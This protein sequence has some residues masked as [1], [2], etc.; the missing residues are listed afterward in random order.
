MPDAREPSHALTVPEQD[1]AAPA[2][3]QLLAM[4]PE[5]YVAAA[6]GAL[7]TELENAIT[8]VGMVV[9]DVTTPE[10]MEAAKQARMVFRQLR[11]AVDRQHKDIKAPILNLSRLIDGRWNQLKD[12]LEPYE[13][14]YHKPIEAEEARLAAIEQAR[15]RAEMDRVAAIERKVA[16]LAQ[17]PAQ[18]LNQPSTHIETILLALEAI[19][20]DESYAEYLPMAQEAKAKA[21]GELQRALDAARRHEADQAELERLRLQ[22]A[23]TPVAED[24]WAPAATLDPGV[25]LWHCYRYLIGLPE[26]YDQLLADV[27]TSLGELGYDLPSH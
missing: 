23:V 6:Y 7:T 11:W 19:V 13:A 5:A 20:L 12:Q 25:V 24:A 21:L 1:N 10:G 16:A 4:E 8:I 2:A 27:A 17:A 15:Q 26:D 14:H 3:P 9:H 22:V 18:A